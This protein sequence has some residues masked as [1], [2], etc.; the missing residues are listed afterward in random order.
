MI[1]IGIALALAVAVTGRAIAQPADCPTTPSADATMP[2]YLDLGGMPGVPAGARGELSANVPVA[3]Y[4]STCAAAEAVPA[5]DILRGTNAGADLLDGGA[6]TD[7][8]TG[9]PR[10][11]VYIEVR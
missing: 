6:S 5:T 4:G 7:I 2:L 11:K 8:L 10:G 9:K 3:P 1:R